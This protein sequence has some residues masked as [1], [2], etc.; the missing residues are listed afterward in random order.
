L[1]SSYIIF[2]PLFNT[3]TNRASDSE[4]TAQLAAGGKNIA[5][6]AFA[7]HGGEVPVQ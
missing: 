3:Q 6:F 2:Y 4:S 1:E 7:K 5:A